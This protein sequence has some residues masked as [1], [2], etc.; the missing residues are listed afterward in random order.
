MSLSIGNGVLNQKQSPA[1]YNDI[2]ANR[3]TPGF[4]GRLFVSNDTGQIYYDNG[5]AWILIADAGAGSGNLE[6]VTTNGN[7]TDKGINIT[8]NNLVIGSS[9]VTTVLSNAYLNF[10]IPGQNLQLQVSGSAGGNIYTTLQNKS[11]VVALTS[12]IT[13]ALSSYLPLAAG[14]GSTLSG[15]LYAGYPESNIICDGGIHMPNGNSSIRAATDQSFNI[16]TFNSGSK[17]NALKITQAG[18]ATFASSVTASS[19]IKSGGTSSQFLMA[20]GSV[21]TSVL[22]SGAYLPLAAGSGSPLTGHLYINDVGTYSSRVYGGSNIGRLILTNYDVTSYIEVHG[23]SYS[24]L[25]SAIQINTGSGVAATF[26]ADHST[27]LAGALSGTSASFSGTSLKLGTQSTIVS[28]SGLLLGNDASTIEM[29]SSTYANG[30][31]AKLQQLDPS[32][33][34][35][36]TVLYGRANSTSWTERVRV[37]NSTGAATFASSVDAASYKAGGVPIL[38]YSATAVQLAANSYWQSLEFWTNGNS[39][40]K[41]SS[42]GETL[43]NTTT[44]IGGNFKLQ[45]N[46]AINC[47]GFSGGG[48]QVTTSQT[49]S[50]NYFY[51][52][53]NGL[54][55]NTLTLPTAL[56]DNRQVWIK[57]FTAFPVTIA[58]PAGGGI[59]VNGIATPQATITLGTY[60]SAMFSSDG[61]TNKYIQ[62]Y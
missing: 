9:G 37:N 4:L 29:V 58:A 50:D 18:L 48:L 32:D 5:T 17:V 3:P 10:V 61:G 26:N 14:S 8:S 16:D 55:G 54:G 46:G 25:P 42:T 27:T 47:N 2:F 45:V 51:F 21:N 62:W 44:N 35:T 39:R 1:I 11:G 12:D 38:G 60:A 24:Y 31:G 7:T 56:T 6:T 49:L 19:F 52:T 40:L 30:Y 53:Y 33:G 13:T 20:D 23:S 34:S 15:S 22:P 41:I 36:Y 59:L 43:I 57:N 28:T